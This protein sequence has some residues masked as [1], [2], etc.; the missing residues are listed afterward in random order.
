MV[1]TFQDEYH[2]QNYLNRDIHLTKQNS[3]T[4]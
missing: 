4:V 2:Y 3:M 1:D